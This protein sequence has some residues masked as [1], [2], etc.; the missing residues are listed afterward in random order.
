[1]FRVLAAWASFDY[2]R[3]INTDGNVQGLL[4]QPTPIALLQRWYSLIR[5]KRPMYQDF[6]K[7]LLRAAERRQTAA[8][9]TCSP[10]T[11]RI[12]LMPDGQRTCAPRD[13]RTPPHHECERGLW[14]S[15][16]AVPRTS[17]ISKALPSCDASL[18]TP[19]CPRALLTPSQA[20]VHPG[21]ITFT[22]PKPGPARASSRLLETWKCAFSSSRDP[23]ILDLHQRADL[24]AR[25]EESDGLF[26]SHTLPKLCGQDCGRF[27][28]RQSRLAK[29]GQ[30][31]HACQGAGAA[32]NDESARRCFRFE[33]FWI[34]MDTNTASFRGLPEGRTDWDVDLLRSILETELRPKRDW[35]NPLSTPTTYERD[36]QPC[37]VSLLEGSDLPLRRNQQ[38]I[39][40]IL[41][42]TFTDAFFISYE[43]EIAHLLSRPLYSVA[44]VH[45]PTFVM[46]CTALAGPGWSPNADEIGPTLPQVRRHL[47]VRCVLPRCDLL[48]LGRAVNVKKP[49]F[50]GH[51]KVKEA[52]QGVNTYLSTKDFKHNVKYLV[53]QTEAKAMIAH[54]KDPTRE[55]AKSV[56]SHLETRDT[57]ILIAAEGMEQQF[58]ELRGKSD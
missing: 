11:G 19:S 12:P 42:P 28:K 24:L 38:E 46:G 1:M 52:W 53:M 23:E 58:D 10:S 55:D 6:L 13:P 51:G 49:F 47:F 15:Y 40:Q 54:K 21:G 4:L 5:E 44:V 41:P 50:A 56:A 57:A 8:R 20:S 31:E 9:R 2:Q 33:I 27:A 35:L 3:R 32:S 25:A 22:T 43:Q 45:L 37:L 34:E 48:E 7:P 26:W 29:L 39:H 30:E 17:L 14:S 36:E 16:G 18:N